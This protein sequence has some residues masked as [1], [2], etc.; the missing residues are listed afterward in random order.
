MTWTPG[1]AQIEAAPLSRKLQNV[2]GAL[3]AGQGWITE[4]KRK[5]QTAQ[6]LA[7][8][9]AVTAYVTAYD[10]ADTPA[11][12]EPH[13][14]TRPA[15]RRQMP[16]RGRFGAGQPLRRQCRRRARRARIWSRVLSTC[17]V[18]PMTPRAECRRRG[19]ALG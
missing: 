6:A 5:Y 17:W 15:M 14:T 18:S 4:A 10:A 11:D 8:V 19:A 7:D 1:R 13:D 16:N 3:A 12:R 9:D 2:A